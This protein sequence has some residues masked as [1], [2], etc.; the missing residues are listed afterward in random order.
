MHC[1]RRNVRIPP[2][3]VRPPP[4]PHHPV[5]TTTTGYVCC[6]PR[7][8][9]P[10][11]PLP[12]RPSLPFHRSNG[13]RGVPSGILLTTHTHTHAHTYSHVAAVH[14]A[15]A[16][17]LFIYTRIIC[18]HHYTVVVVPPPLSDSHS[19]RFSPRRRHQGSLYCVIGISCRP[20]P[21]AT[22]VVLRPTAADPTT[23]ARRVL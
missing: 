16:H 11:P 9:P 18:V 22:P 8:C 5:I 6:Y 13:S 21:R 17:V 14:H 12:R 10:L 23:Y 3:P 19:A 15:H 1:T 20:S 4:Q 2:D 7:H